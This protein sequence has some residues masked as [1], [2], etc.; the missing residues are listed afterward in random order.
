M[1]YSLYNQYKKLFILKVYIN[2]TN[3]EKE[4]YFSPFFVDTYTYL[5][6]NRQQQSGKR[7]FR[8]TL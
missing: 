8:A 1:K 6:G 7:L 5:R 3:Y 4:K 2:F